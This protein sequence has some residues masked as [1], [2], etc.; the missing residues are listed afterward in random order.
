MTVLSRLRAQRG[1]PH[2]G[3]DRCGGRRSERDPCAY[4]LIADRFPAR[5]RGTA[6]GIYSAGPVPRQRPVAADRRGDRQGVERGVARRRAARPGGLA[7]GLR[8][9]RPAGAG[10]RGVGLFAARARARRDGRNSQRRRCASLARVRRTAVPAHSAVD[11]VRRRAAR[12]RV[13]WRS[14]S[15]VPR[16]SPRSAFLLARATGNVPQF[17]FLGIGF[18]AVFSWACATA[19]ARPADLC[20][21]LGIAGLHGNRHRLRG[22]LLR[23]LCGV[24]LG[25][26]LRR[27]GLRGR[28]GNARRDDRRTCGTGRFS[29][30]GVR[31]QAGRHAAGPVSR[32]GGSW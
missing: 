15:P 10:A 31:G 4:S 25:G 7:G 30:S 22:G 17:L 19:R 29:R 20:A 26:A 8:R 21:D 18:Y 6:L 32:P 9:G 28:Q 27:A 23:R 16:S 12:V 13:R 2:R 1:D 5:V 11:P 24:L 3:P 14:I